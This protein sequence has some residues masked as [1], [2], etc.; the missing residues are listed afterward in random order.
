MAI[1]KAHRAVQPFGAL[2]ADTPNQFA[3][4]L[5]GEQHHA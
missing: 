3:F 2:A 1:Q 4:R 5:V